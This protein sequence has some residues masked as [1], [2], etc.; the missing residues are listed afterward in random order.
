MLSWESSRCFSPLLRPPSTCSNWMVNFSTHFCLCLFTWMWRLPCLSHCQVPISS[1]QFSWGEP[2]FHFQYPQS[3][4]LNI[5]QNQNVEVYSAW[6]L[7]FNY[8]RICWVLNCRWFCF[9]YLLVCSILLR[10]IQVLWLIFTILHR[11]ALLHMQNFFWWWFFPTSSI[12]L[13]LRWYLARL[14]SFK[15]L[16]C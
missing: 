12:L 4:S 15:E 16:N 3:Y 2:K 5:A 10:M 13:L 14:D 6:C 8:F 11:L 7:C 9:V 1:H